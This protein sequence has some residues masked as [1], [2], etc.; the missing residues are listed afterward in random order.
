MLVYDD[1]YDWEGWGGELR[2]GSGECRLRIYDLTEDGTKGATH[3]RPVV[4]VLTDVPG[5]KLSVRS[6]A[7]HIATMVVRDFDLDFN[8]MLWVEYY[9]ERRYGAGKVRVIPERYEAVEFTWH[10]DMAIEPKWRTLTAPILDTVRDLLG[11]P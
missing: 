4:V 1:I 9:P 6:C 8:R 11:R 10:E 2:L 3:L 5:S 7:G